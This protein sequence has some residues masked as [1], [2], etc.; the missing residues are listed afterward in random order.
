MKTLSLTALLLCLA[1]LCQS[2]FAVIK[3]ESNGKITY[4]DEPCRNG[5]Q[6]DISSAPAPDADA[7]ARRA[8]R[9]KHELQ[10]LEG[11]RRRQEAKDDK[12]RARAAKA[13]ATKQKKCVTLALHKRWADEDAA[14][15]TGKAA[16]KVKR[17]AHRAGEKFESECG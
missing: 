3:C 5:R 16:D 2:A 1:S 9:E 14:S 17:K 12:E 10:R 8:A 7:D 13:N 15:A 4:S 11:Q 6:L